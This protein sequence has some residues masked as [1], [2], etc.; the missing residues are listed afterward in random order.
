MMGNTRVFRITDL[1]LRESLCTDQLS[2]I[3]FILAMAGPKLSMKSLFSYSLTSKVTPRIWKLSPQGIVLARSVWSSKSPTIMP[4][5]L[6]RL[7]PSP[8]IFLNLSIN[9][10]A[11]TKESSSWRKREVSS[12]NCIILICD[13]SR[14]IP[15][16]KWIRPQDFC[17]FFDGQDE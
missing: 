9:W 2:Q 12:A 17:Q 8:E 14:S 16:T 11:L 10:R 13:S 5:D 6:C 7:R 4:W 15:F 3:F 1:S